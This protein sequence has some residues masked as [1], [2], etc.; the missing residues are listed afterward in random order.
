MSHISI[1]PFTLSDLNSL[2]DCYANGNIWSDYPWDEHRRCPS[3]PEGKN[4]FGLSFDGNHCP[5]CE[6]VL[7]PFWEVDKVKKDIRQQLGR[8]QSR[9]F[10]AFADDQ[11]VGFTWGYPVTMNTVIV[12]NDLDLQVPDEASILAR[13]RMGIRYTHNLGYIDEVGLIPE[14]R[15]QG[16]ARRLTL[17]LLT[18]FDYECLTTVLLRTDERATRAVILYEKL[19]FVRDPH[20]TDPIYTHRGYWHVDATG[21][22]YNRE[23]LGRDVTP[24]DL[25]SER[26]QE[27]IKNPTGGG[28]EH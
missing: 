8:E 20:L 13:H 12:I 15:K 16:I 3:C 4:N 10:L 9:G 1:R 28:W 26:I 22:W 14:F 25:Q 27:E 6:S 21:L 11:I 24:Y 19:G 2:A 5:K 7:V 23:Q 17:A 18:H